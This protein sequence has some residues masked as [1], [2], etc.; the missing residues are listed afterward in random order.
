M[1]LYVNPF[2]FGIWIATAMCKDCIFETAKPQKK[3]E[4]QFMLSKL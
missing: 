3:S 4:I 2:W 1:L